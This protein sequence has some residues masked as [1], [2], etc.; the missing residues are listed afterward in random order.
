MAY[1]NAL[2][3]YFSLDS[4]LVNS[5]DL[6][7]TFKNRSGYAFKDENLLVLALT[8]SS[9]AIGPENHNE[10]LEFLGDRVLALVIADELSSRFPDAKEGEL[11]RRLNTMVRKETC[12]KV[13]EKLGLGE[14][15]ASLAGK[16]AAK[17]GVFKGQNV[18][19]DAC[20]AML[21]AIYKDSDYVTARDITLKLWEPFLDLKTTAQKDPKS[22][23]QEWALSK[24]LDT[25]IYKE[26]SR[27]GPDHA[28]EFVMAVNIAK[29][30]SQQGIANSKRAAEQSAAARF[31]AVNK[32]EI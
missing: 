20:E 25:P 8:H 5:K 27:Q 15:M 16:K 2:E 24:G 29:H 12:A 14:L 32:I 6:V 21:A 4:E 1:R 13:A 22:A 28:P 9:Q 31:I 7:A 3:S 23:L 10:R 26:V 19:G 11:A 30:D 17:T 18:M